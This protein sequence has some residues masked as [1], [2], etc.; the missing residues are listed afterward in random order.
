MKCFSLLLLTLL[1]LTSCHVTDAKITPT[2]R[3]QILR[4]TLKMDPP[5]MDPRVGVDT[6]SDGVIRMLFEGLTYMERDGSTQLALAQSFELSSDQTV[7]TFHLKD[8]KWSDG[9]P[10][11]A[12][13]FEGAWKNIVDPKTL[14]PNANLLYLLKNGRAIKL[15]ELPVDTLGVRATDDKTLVVELEHPQAS[16]LDALSNCAFY[17]LPSKMRDHPF[18]YDNYICCGPFQLKS[19]QLQD[20]IILTKNPHYWDVQQVRLDEV[21]FYVVMVGHGLRYEPILI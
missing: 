12:Y 5:S 16:F 15:G 18:S 19:Y 11:T 4:T 17:P 6:V 13:D 14:A 8:V 7:Y 20:K 3:K 21:H 2:E 10:L 9:S 1:S